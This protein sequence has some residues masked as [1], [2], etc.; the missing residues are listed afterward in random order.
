M[1]CHTGYE[2]FSD[3]V[4]NAGIVYRSAKQT[5]VANS[6]TEAEVI[7]LHDLVQHLLWVQGIY[8]SLGV[9]YEQPSVIHDDNEATYLSSLVPLPSSTSQAEANISPVSTS[10]Y[11]S[12]SRARK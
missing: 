7:A 10:S 3:S 6:S 9:S 11:M 8:V 5:T 4:G 1:R 12:T 2:F